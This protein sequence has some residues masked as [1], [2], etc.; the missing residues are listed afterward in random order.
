MVDY[1]KPS[2][3]GKQEEP[4]DKEERKIEK[5]VVGE[6]IT[7]KKPVFRRVKE[8]FFGGEASVVAQ[9]LGA[10]VLL[11]AL[12]NM[13]LDFVIKGAEGMIFGNG[14]PGRTRP[15]PSYSPHLTVG[16]TQAQVNYNRIRNSPPVVNSGYRAARTRMGFHEYVLSSREDARAV[17]GQM[18]DIVDGYGAVSVAD[19][20]VL[21]GEPSTHVDQN[22]GWMYLNDADIRQIREGYL[23]RLPSPDPLN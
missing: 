16:Q 11:P 12:R 4:A 15:K 13:V 10:E 6:V 3:N 7:R 21:L 1:S 2:D 14:A 9:Y 8:T 19:L 23:L 5:V 20:N 18:Q 17:L 22:W